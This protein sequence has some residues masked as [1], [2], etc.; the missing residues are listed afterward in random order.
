MLSGSTTSVSAVQDP[1]AKDSMLITPSGMVTL[2]SNLFPLNAPFPMLVT[3]LPLISAG[4][5]SAVSLPTYLLMRKVV[6][7]S[8]NSAT[9]QG[10]SEKPFTVA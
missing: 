4:I 1:K 2:V 10:S 8:F 9:R 7:S 5:T 3:F 6:P